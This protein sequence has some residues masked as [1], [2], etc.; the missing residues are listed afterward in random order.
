MAC[1]FVTVLS[2]VCKQDVVAGEEVGIAN[3][4]INVYIIVIIIVIIIIIIN[5]IVIKA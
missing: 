3:I 2:G 1:V 4:E 5:A